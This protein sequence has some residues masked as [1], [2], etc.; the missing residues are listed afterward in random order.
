MKYQKVK[1][2]KIDDPFN[3]QVGDLI[4]HKTR[5]CEVTILGYDSIFLGYRVIFHDVNIMG[6]LPFESLLQNCSILA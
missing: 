5:L 2:R 6:N 3:L 1:L 4:F